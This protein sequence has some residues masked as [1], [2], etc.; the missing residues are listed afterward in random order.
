MS[1]PKYEDRVLTEVDIFTTKD[2]SMCLNSF[3]FGTTD[4]GREGNGRDELE[5]NI[6]GEPIS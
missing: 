4:Q 5:K 2:K 3:T 6:I 1:L